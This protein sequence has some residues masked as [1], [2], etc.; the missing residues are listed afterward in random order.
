ML[1]II[2]FAPL[3]ASILAGFFYKQLGE[4]FVIFSAITLLFISAI[5][6]WIV[7]LGIDHAEIQEVIFFRW[8]ESGSLKVNWGMRLDTLTAIMLVVINTISAFVH[9]Y[10]VGYMAHDPNWDANETFRPRFFSYLSLFTFAML[11]LVTSNNLV[12]LFFGWEGVG[13][14][15]YLLIGFY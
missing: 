8:I 14:A 13:L 1:Q 9:L 11:M 5:F 4:R 10:S 6:S 3:I 7:F 2:L 12:Q 15:S